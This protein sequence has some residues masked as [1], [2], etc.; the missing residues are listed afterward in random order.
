MPDDDTWIARRDET[1]RLP[2]DEV[3]E[4]TPDG[5]PYERPEIVLLFKAK[6]SRAKDEADLAAV[7]PRLSAER[8]RLLA[9]WIE[10]VH[11]GHFWLPDLA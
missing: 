1:I 5:I 11:P 4:H 7:L 9:T 2:Y 6:H 3:I 8:R 10:R